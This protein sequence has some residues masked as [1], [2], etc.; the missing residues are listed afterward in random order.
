VDG[1]ILVALTGPRIGEIWNL[2]WD[3]FDLERGSSA[4]RPAARRGVLAGGAK[5]R[6]ERQVPM[7]DDMWALLCRSDGCSLAVSVP[8]AHEPSSP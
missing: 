8:E 2:R 7:S 5:G 3:H 1:F 4:F 6:N